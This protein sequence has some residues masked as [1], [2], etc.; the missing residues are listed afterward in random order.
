MTCGEATPV[1]PSSST[2]DAWKCVGVLDKALGMASELHAALKEL[3]PAPGSLSP[4]KHAQWRK[5]VDVIYKSA[6]FSESAE[7]LEV[8]KVLASRPTGATPQQTANS[9]REVR[10]DDPPPSC[11]VCGAEMVPDG[12]RC[13]SCKSTTHATVHESVKEPPK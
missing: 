10:T 6:E 9:V 1:V 3:I 12:F 8:S 11:H 7:Y 5:V 2:P 4:E 13:R